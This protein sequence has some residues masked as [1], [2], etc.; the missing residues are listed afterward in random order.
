MA[1]DTSGEQISLWRAG[2][3][4][5]KCLSP[6]E[7]PGVSVATRQAPPPIESKYHVREYPNN[8]RPLVSIYGRSLLAIY[9]RMLASLYVLHT[10]GSTARGRTKDVGRKLPDVRSC[11]YHA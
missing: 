1:G 3:A 6:L 5:R 8:M 9:R 4:T 2:V 7:K 10:R 11:G